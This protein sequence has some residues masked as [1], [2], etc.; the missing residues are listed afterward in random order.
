MQKDSF[1]SWKT[2]SKQSQFELNIPERDTDYNKKYAH[3]I[4]TNDFFNMDSPATKRRKEFEKR[5]EALGLSKRP[6]N[7]NKLK[8][9]LVSDI[10]S[11][12]KASKKKIKRITGTKDGKKKRRTVRKDK[13]EKKA[14]L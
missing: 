7:K 12:T 14:K 5:M 10:Q 9:K 2:N 11:E 4:P 3:L 8:L 13:I 6:L 1:F